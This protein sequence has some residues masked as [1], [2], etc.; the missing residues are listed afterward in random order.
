MRRPAPGYDAP[1]R[2]FRIRRPD[3]VSPYQEMARQEATNLNLSFANR[4]LARHDLKQTVCR[5]RFMK[6]Q[7]NEPGAPLYA[8]KRTAKSLWQQYRIYGDWLELQC[9][10]FFHTL[11]VPTKEIQ[12]IEV[13]PPVWNGARGITWGVK[14]DNCDL[15]RHVL[16]TKRSGLFKR[17]GFTPDDPERFIAVCRSI[18]LRVPD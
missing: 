9:W 6:T 5:N 18:G 13:R 16:L 11:V 17:I 3:D 8:S 1:L 2:V 15:N 4:V 12:A 7:P 14:I 10:I